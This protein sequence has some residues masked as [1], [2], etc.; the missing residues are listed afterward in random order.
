MGDVLELLGGQVVAQLGLMQ[1]LARLF[2]RHV[3]QVAQL[4]DAARAGLE[5]LAV[6]AVHG[7][8]AEVFQR[9]LGRISGQIGGAE[10]LFEMLGL[11]F[12]DDVEDQVRAD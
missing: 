12:V 6:G 4:Q 1:A 2:R 3:D 9:L 7:A 5:R 8:E 11:T 10:D